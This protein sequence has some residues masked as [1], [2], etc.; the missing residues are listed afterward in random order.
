[1]PITH[2]WD[3]EA[4]TI[5]R[6]DLDDSWQW[7]DFNAVLK[8]A[9]DVVAAKKSKVD[10]IMCINSNLPPGNAF[11]YLRNAGGS[12]P[13][14]VY[15]TVIVNKAGILLERLVGTIDRAKGWDGP[16]MVKT[17][18]EARAFLNKS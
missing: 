1:M 14:N 5:Y 12:Q 10:F 2:Q 16:E 11:I 18:D 17:L 4:K 3:N 6:L 8:Q 9:Y 15:R 13:A 7:D